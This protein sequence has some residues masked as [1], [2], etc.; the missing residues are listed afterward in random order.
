MKQAKKITALTLLLTFITVF[1]M[2]CSNSG[3]NNN[4]NETKNTAGETSASEQGTTSE[5]TPAAGADYGGY[6]FK[7]LGFDSYSGGWKAVG[8]SEVESETVNGDPINDAVYNRD[9]EIDEMYNINIQEVLY[10]GPNDDYGTVINKAMA[11]VM[12]GTNE[13]DAGLT[14]GNSMPQLIGTKN[15]T[16]DLLSI[17]ELDLTKSW[18]NQNSIKEFTLAGKLHSV[19]GDISLWNT[20]AEIVFYFNKQLIEQNGLEDPYSLVR[21]GD[22]TW[23]KLG[24]MAKAVT[25]DINGDGVI[26]RFDQIGIA[27]EDAT[28]YEAVLCAGEHF[29]TKDAQD[30]PALNTN[31]D[32]ISAVVDKAMPVLRSQDYAYATSDLYASGKYKNAFFE[33]TMPKFR[34]NQILFYTQQLM[35]AL[36]LRDMQADFG[37]LPLPKLDASQN[38][39]YSTASDYFN[40]YAWIPSTNDDPARTANI[41]QAMGY[42]SQQIVIPALFDVTITNKALRDEDSLEMLQLI[43]TSRVYDLTTIYNWGGILDI[44]NSIYKKRINDLASAMEK[45]A[46]KINAAMQQTIDSLTN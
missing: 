43:K 9:A 18:W 29:A 27:S 36:N 16:Y 33:F 3:N 10:G 11:V 12:A 44:Y 26:D 41:L 2:S 1:F 14:P 40:T 24:E 23:D 6:T 5:F 39:Y 20:M 34:D 22:W 31:L 45:G 42:Y 8:Y 19:T 35:V 7:M 37:V 30:M 21:S 46:G 13:F 25:R 4:V 17:P 32:R 15:M 28:L 38:G